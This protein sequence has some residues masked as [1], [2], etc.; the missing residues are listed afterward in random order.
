MCWD[1]PRCANMHGYAIADGIKMCRVAGQEQGGELKSRCQCQKK[2]TKSFVP[3]GTTPHNVN[4]DGG[5]SSI[6][7]QTSTLFVGF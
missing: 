1:A 4:I 7:A 3:G 2:D 6:G 5:T